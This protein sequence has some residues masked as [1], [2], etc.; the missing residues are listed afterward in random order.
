[1]MFLFS[2]LARVGSAVGRVIAPRLLRGRRATGDF[3]GGPTLARFGG[4]ACGDAPAFGLVASLSA[5]P[6]PAGHARPLEINRRTNG[7]I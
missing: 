3:F 4:W 6:A 7:G 2:K 1:M 5:A